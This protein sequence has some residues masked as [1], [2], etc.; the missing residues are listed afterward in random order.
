MEQ[1]H[2]MGKGFPGDPNPQH[3]QEALVGR[4]SAVDCQ[5]NNQTHC[6]APNISVMK[7]EA[8]ADCATYEPRA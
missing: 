4:C 1:D 3:E 2:P 5:Y 7:H 6:H 8:H